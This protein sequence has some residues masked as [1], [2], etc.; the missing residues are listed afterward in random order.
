V[1]VPDQLYGLGPKAQSGGLLELWTARIA[2]TTAAAQI[3]VLF[4]AIPL[5]RLL[6]L[7]H[8]FGVFTAGAAQTFLRSR[9]DDVDA[10][11]VIVGP[12]WGG[13]AQVGGPATPDYT[14]QPQ[15]VH[16]YVISFG[17][18]LQLTADYSAG[19]AGNV[20]SF[21]VQGW[22]IPKGEVQF[23]GPAN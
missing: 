11:N 1:I 21:V 19:A 8:C 6:V 23:A 7:N 17:H 10:N 4:P 22:L 2:Q 16:G 13:A 20:L 9:L 18:K 15:P 5:D 12:I 3:I 14:F